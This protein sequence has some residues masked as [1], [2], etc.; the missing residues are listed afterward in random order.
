MPMPDGKW[1]ARDVQLGLMR[2]M[3]DRARSCVDGNRVSSW[4]F[5]A[6]SGS[7]VEEVCHAARIGD[8]IEG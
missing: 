4:S 5:V 8:G 3:Q 7:S 6:D 2:G 1:E